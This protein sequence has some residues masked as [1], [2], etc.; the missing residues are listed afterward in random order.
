MFTYVYILHR[1]YLLPETKLGFFPGPFLISTGRFLILAEAFRND[2]IAACGSA[3]EKNEMGGYVIV[4][5][6][7]KM[8]QRNST[9]DWPKF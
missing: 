9:V 7:S 1:L 2:Y 3:A 6:S 5:C 8:T 4:P